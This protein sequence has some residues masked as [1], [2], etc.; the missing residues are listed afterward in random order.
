MPLTTTLSST[1]MTRQVLPV[2]DYGAD[3]ICVVR[4]D[5]D[6]DLW[7]GHFKFVCFHQVDRVECRLLPELRPQASWKADTFS[8]EMPLFLRISSTSST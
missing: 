7:G 1:G 8:S 3:Q 6:F 2:D 5:G 4:V